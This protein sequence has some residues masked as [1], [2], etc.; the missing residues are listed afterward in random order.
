MRRALLILLVLLFCIKI[1]FPQG[2]MS[3]RLGNYES[4]TRDYNEVLIKTSFGKLKLSLVSDNIVH[5][6]I[7]DSEFRSKANYAIIEKGTKSF[8]SVE[9]TSDQLL[10]E[11][12]TLKIKVDKT[13]I[14][15]TYL[16]KDDE[17]LSEDDE[18]GVRWL[19]T[20]VTN[21]KKLLADEKFIGLGEKTG[22]LNRRGQAYENWNNDDFGYEVDAD[23]IYASVPFYIGLHDK[24]TYG[25]FLN[26]SFKTV[27]NFGASNDRFSSF[28]AED[29]ELDYYFFGAPSVDQIIRDY[30][31]ITG[32]IE[33]PPYWSLGFQQCRWSY[34]PDSE[35]LTLAKTFRKKQIPADVIYLDIHYM[36]DYKLFTWDDKRFPDPEATIAELKDMGFHVVVI[37]DPGI[38]TEEGYQAY[39]DGLENDVF[40]KYPDGRN[41]AASVWPGRCY[42]PDFTTAATRKWWGRQFEGLVDV[43]VEGFWNDMNEPA[44]WGNRPPD[45]LEF[46]MEGN[47][48][49]HLEAHNIYGMQMSRATLEG[50]NK[51]KNNERSFILTRAAFSGAQRYTAIWTGDNVASDEHMLLSARMIASMGLSGLSFAGADIGGFKGDPSPALFSRWLSQG[52]FTPFF[53]NHTTNSTRDHEPWAFGEHLES[54]NKRAIELRY[55]MLPYLYSV[56]YES[57]MTGM[58]IARSLAIDYTFDNRIY[59]PVFQNQYL[60]GPA[61][62]V[63]PTLS[64][65]QFAKVYLPGGEWFHLW[66]DKA[67]QGNQEVL[68]EAPLDKLPVFVKA[69]SI[70]PMQAQVQYTNE[71]P[72]DTLKLHVYQ[73]DL[74]TAFE[75]YEDDGKSF[76]Y[77]ENSFYKREITYDPKTGTLRLAKVKGSF[78]SKFQNIEVL[79]HTKTGLQTTKPVKLEDKSMKIKIF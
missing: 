33:L 48:G 9:E 43:G 6:I 64:E 44:S 18:L 60:F 47:R 17:L 46:E 1:G 59:Q 74:P 7:T 11:S 12:Q 40:V 71:I 79:Y 61:F 35:V 36:D 42:F 16:T 28:G 76:D 13:P 57:S 23:P 37:V 63:A 8:K 26:N 45:L 41:Y 31:L 3:K 30:T 66:S 52:V 32:R 39:E 10:L 73:G 21:Y 29:G 65:Q 58:P 70:I 54:V 20:Q 2:R 68:V 5:V 24:V 56:F 14:R 67:Y 4:H 55:K 34:Y 15:I 77:T 51:L 25:I 78:K 27:F 62:L 69:G 53:R 38:K 75:Y 22:P 49:T 72:S 50:V 19:G